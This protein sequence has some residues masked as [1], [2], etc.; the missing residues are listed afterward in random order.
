MTMARWLFLVGVIG[1]VVALLYWQLIIAEGTY[2]GQRVVTWLY[3]LAASRYDSIKGFDDSMEDLFLGE[4]IA[5]ALR[6]KPIPLVL[7]VGTGTG[8]L[9][10]TLLRQPNFHGRLFAI[11]DSTKMLRIAVGRLKQ[12]GDRVWIM[13][14]SAISLPFQDDSFDAVVALEMLEFTPDPE[15]VLMEMVRVLVPGGLLVTT[16]RRGR[17]AFLIPGKT[18][19]VGSLTHTLSSLGVTNIR[20]ESWQ[21]DY[22]LVWGHRSG[23]DVDSSAEPLEVLLCPQCDQ[24]GLHQSSQGIV[25][26]RCGHS[27]AEADGIM[28]AE[29]NPIT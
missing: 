17:D 22:D 24:S 11:D 26:V 21:L 20:I 12:Y 16:R 7:D 19:S 18:H 10:I 13:K 29:S 9:P 3:D 14:R 15:K 4:P 25:C 8:R 1:T 2:L 23:F 28:M 27:I 5:A 6:S